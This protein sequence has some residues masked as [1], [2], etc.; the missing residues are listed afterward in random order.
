MIGKAKCQVCKKEVDIIISNPY[1]GILCEECR[2][3]NT[4]DKK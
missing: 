1:F 3:G 4:Y 2:Q